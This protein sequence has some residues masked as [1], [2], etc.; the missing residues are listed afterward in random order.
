MTAR[1]EELLQVGLLG[2][3]IGALPQHKVPDRVIGTRGC[4]LL[5]LGHATDH[6]RTPPAGLEEH[7]LYALRLPFEPLL[8]D[9]PWYAS[10]PPMSTNLKTPS[11][12]TQRDNI[13]RY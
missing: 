8:R 2:L 12:V 11:R 10:T 4:L 6:A 7:L 5:G 9:L 3:E 1:D 13:A